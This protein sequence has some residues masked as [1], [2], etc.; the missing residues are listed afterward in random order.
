MWFTVYLQQDAF[1]TVGA[2]VPIKPQ[3]LTF[4][5]IRDVIDTDFTFDT[6]FRSVRLL[7]RLT[8]D[9]KN[10]HYAADSTPDYQAYLDRIQSALK[11]TEP[12]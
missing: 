1:D 9:F 6:K 12:S 11:L 2:T 8:G 3:K 10:F 7:H 4:H 5:I